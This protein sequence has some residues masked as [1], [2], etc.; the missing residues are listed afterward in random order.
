[1]SLKKIPLVVGRCHVFNMFFSY[2][3]KELWLARMSWSWPSPWTSWGSST[4]GQSLLTTSP[5]SRGT[6]IIYYYISSSLRNLADGK[7]RCFLLLLFG[8]V[9]LI[10]CNSVF[11]PGSGWRWGSGSISKRNSF[12]TWIRIGILMYDDPEHYFIKFDIKYFLNVLLCLSFF[13]KVWKAKSSSHR[14]GGEG[15]RGFCTEYLC[16]E[17]RC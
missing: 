11:N 5:C 6:V 12:W 2:I 14:C 7:H 1:M 8:T 3:R 10:I 15:G 4:G 16:Q 13:C 9:I 17:W